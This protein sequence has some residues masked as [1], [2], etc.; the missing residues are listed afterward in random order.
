M[1]DI[2]W[3]A[4]LRDDES[5]GCNSGY[6]CLLEAFRDVFDRGEDCRSIFKDVLAGKADTTLYR[7]VFLKEVCGGFLNRGLLQLDRPKFFIFPRGGVPKH[8]SSLP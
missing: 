1:T 5:Y 2:Q 6:Y 7:K 3:A 4:M 8:R